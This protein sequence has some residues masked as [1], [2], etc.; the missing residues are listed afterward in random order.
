MALR[1][2]N[3]AN[4][5]MWKSVTLLAMAIWLL[6][7]VAVS[8]AATTKF[9]DKEK[10][11]KKYEEDTLLVKFKPDVQSEDKEKIHIKLGSIK[12]KDYPSLNIQ[13]VKL[14]KDITP[15][16]AAAL[17]EAEPEVEYAEPNYLFTS[18]YT[19]NDPLFDYLWGLYNTVQTQGSPAADIN[20]VSA[21]DITAGGNDIV[22]AVIDS[23]VDSGHPDLWENLWVNQAEY[24][25]TL[26]VDDDGN[27]YIDD[28]HGINTYSSSSDPT[29]DHG[30]GTHVAGTIGAVGNN[31]IGITGVNW[32]IQIIPCKFLNS[33]GY[34][35]TDGALECL[36]YVRGLKEKGVNV[37]AT[38]NSWG[39]SGYSQSLYEAVDLQRESGILFVAAAGNGNSDTD[40]YDF[41]PANY[42]L[43]NVLSVA[44]T[45][46]TGNKAWFSNYGK[47]TVHVS[48]PGVDIVSLRASGTDMYGDGQHF[49][50]PGDPYSQYCI[51]NGTSM[52]APHVTGL[53]ALIKSQNPDRDWID[54][55][56]LILS[57]SDHIVGYALTQAGRIDAYRSLTC[58]DRP[59]IA[60]LKYPACFQAGIP[61]TLAAL[62]INCESPLWPVTV[63]ASSGEAVNL[64]DDGVFPDLVAGDGIFSA[65]WTPG[66][67]FSFLTFSSPAGTEVVPAPSIMTNSL[68]I[69]L[70]NTNYSQPLQVSGGGPPYV[71][72]VHSG[73]LPDGLNLNSSTGEI[74]GIP[75]TTGTRYF[76][77][78]VTDSR[79]AFSMKTF[80]I[81]VK[82]VDLVITSVSGPG[83]ASLGQQVAIT[84]TVKNQGSG[85]SHGFNVTV[86]LSA[87]PTITTG[88]RAMTTFIASPLAAGSELTRTT[89]PSIPSDIVPGTYYVG[90]IADT[91]NGVGE[92]NE[93]N[94]SFTG[95][96]ISIISEVDLIITSVSGPASASPR[97][98]VD[99]SI[100]VKNQGTASGN[101]FHVIVYLSPDPT[102]TQ[103]DL[104]VGSRYLSSLAGGAQQALTINFTVPATLTGT[105]YLGAIADGRSFVIESDENNNS[106]TGNQ[107]TVTQSD[108]A[109]SSL[110]GPATATRGQQISVTTT[111]NNGGDGRSG[112]FYV[113]VYLS[114][115]TVI[116]PWNE[117]SQSGDLEIGSIYVT[118]LGA[119]A[120]QALTINPTIP[121]A[122]TGN[123][124]LGAIADSRRNV[125][126][127]N[128]NNN[129]FCAAS[130]ISITSTIPDLVITSVSGPGDARPGDQID[131]SATVKN[132]GSGSAGAF[133][134]SVYLSAD[135]SITAGDTLIGTASVTG[136]AAGVEQA[137]A[138]NY[139]IPANV[140]GTYYL[141]AIADT[142][143]TVAESD[144]GNNSRAGNPISIVPDSSDVDLVAISISGPGNLTPGKEISVTVKVKNQ[145][146]VSSGG[147]YVSAYL[148]TDSGITTGDIP[149]GSI[150][151]AELGSGTQQ[152]LSVS[153]TVPDFAAGT[154]Y[155]GAIADPYGEVVETNEDNN[156][157]AGKEVK[158]K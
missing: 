74:S 113:S 27:G 46:Q 101:G 32:Q 10:E 88:D 55:K 108:L 142:G 154:Y 39:G 118:D 114:T 83:S 121:T 21:W 54:I 152:T 91:G 106:F 12:I 149:I 71:W 97:E 29:D 110:S 92:S 35:Y 14:K 72:S 42:D 36:E 65:S 102:I 57:G 148:S 1:A 7:S 111:V 68:P 138:V 119:G 139:A 37:I 31:D 98:Q 131:V 103:G 40:I 122:L 67:E 58:T 117:G 112:W 140:T 45:D 120:Q 105:H 79:T 146:S 134:V 123:F 150:Y 104:E 127:S 136:L 129:S 89:N 9:D 81:T 51:A 125:S 20:A 48:A 128:E 126:E 59:V 38:N 158:T 53:A 107:I 143:S 16:D 80:S 50:P 17:Y 100:T 44:A 30:H 8:G 151:V 69:G 147:F 66:S 49:I 22:V 94:N 144:E 3:H 62:S 2:T 78:K 145:G 47:R 70:V 73:S 156:S 85:D 75:S 63:T 60:A 25:G 109:I 34:G 82:E 77:V 141:G 157:V 13:Y 86:Y 6:V 116:T 61:T 155:L 124:Y 130:Q 28:I 23:G 15:E 33:E 26:G 133:V 56:N 4:R 18:Q 5:A 87:D 90:A 64:G 76:T 137:L 95:N 96:P 52:A 84:T 99:V 132:Q 115:D 93:S 24:A 11:K 41:Y 19:P 153:C 43:P 135:S